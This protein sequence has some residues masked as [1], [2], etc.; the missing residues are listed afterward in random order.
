MTD[1]LPAADE[2]ADVG[3]GR[4]RVGG[5][6]AH[7]T[8]QALASGSNSGASCMVDESLRKVAVIFLG[9]PGAGKGT[10]AKLIAKHYKVPHISTGDILRE[11]VARGTELGQKAK[12]V[13][14]RGEGRLSLSWWTHL[15]HLP[16]ATPR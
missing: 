2:S 14:A 10:Q 13:M 16:S 8:V 15:Q 4:K 7:P 11:N 1:S 5:C 3:T 9:P 12:A 6:A